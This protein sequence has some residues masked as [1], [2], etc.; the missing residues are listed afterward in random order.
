MKRKI[1]LYLKENT[2]QTLNFKRK[3]A[4]KKS[5]SCFLDEIFSFQ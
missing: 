5:I 4:N 1:N 2:I 3:K